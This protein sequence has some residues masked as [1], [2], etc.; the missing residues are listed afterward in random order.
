MHVILGQ[1]PGYPIPNGAP[2][3]TAEDFDLWRDRQAEESSRGYPVIEDVRD[4][5]DDDGRG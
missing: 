5:E 1:Y 4:Q 3:S 2:N